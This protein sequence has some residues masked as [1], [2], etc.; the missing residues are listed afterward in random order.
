MTTTVNIHDA[1]THFSKLL[2]RV[3]NG[4]EVIIARAGEPVAILSPLPSQMTRRVPGNDAGKVVI[5]PVFEESL[6]EFDDL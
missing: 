1:K 5:T 3:F 2:Q 6:P 4:E